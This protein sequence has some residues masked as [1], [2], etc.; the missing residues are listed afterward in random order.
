[1][2]PERRASGGNG[3]VKDVDKC[4]GENRRPAGTDMGCQA[5]GRDACLVEG[6]RGIDIADATDNLLIEKR[7]LDRCPASGKSGEKSL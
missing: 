2:I 3:P 4:P 1:M 6:F 5:A 7:R